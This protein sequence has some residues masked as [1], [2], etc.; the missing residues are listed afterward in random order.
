L[1][2]RAAIAELEVPGTGSICSYQ[3]DNEGNYN[4]TIQ[5]GG[6]FRNHQTD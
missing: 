3:C 4:I 1:R 6:F 2:L 5:V